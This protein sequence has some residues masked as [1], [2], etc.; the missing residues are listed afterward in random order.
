VGDMPIFVAHDSADVWSHPELFYLDED[1]NPIAVAGGPPDAF[2]ATGQLWGNPHYRWDEMER[3]GYA[4]WIERFRHLFAMVDIVR[5]DHFRG[6]AAAWS[7]PAGNPTAEHGEWVPTPGRALFRALRPAL[8][9]L[10][11]IAEDLGF[12]TPDVRELRAEFGFPG[13]KI[14]QFAFDGD[15][16]NEHLPHNLSRDCAVYTGTHDNETTQAWYSSL[17]AGERSY[18]EAYAGHP[19]Q[20]VC[21]DL[22]RLAFASVAGL[23]TVPLQDV[24]RLGHDA[25]MNRPGTAEGNWEWRFS[26]Y[27]LTEERLEELA[28]LTQTFGRNL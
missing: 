18:L 15:P 14:L 8:G 10:P 16:A 26:V 6:F 28:T 20:D 21:A 24:L 12:I 2:T 9:E 11:V 13:M 3:T 25:R 5:V 7:V 19:T 1:G 27:Q 4:W 23:A 17:P 22:M